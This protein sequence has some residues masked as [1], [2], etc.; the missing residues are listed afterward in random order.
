MAPKD[1]QKAYAKRSRK[2]GKEKWDE[3]EQLLTKAVEIYPKYAVAWSELGHVQLRKD[4]AVPARHSFEQSIAADPK[5][6]N[7]YRGLAELDT[8][9]KQWPE[10]VTVTGQLLA[11]EPRQL[12]RCLAA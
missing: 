1:A 9:Q 8:Q 10:L 5:Y 2:G 7:P 4:E 11:L 6:V 12:P 3:A